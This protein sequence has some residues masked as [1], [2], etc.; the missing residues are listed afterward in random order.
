MNAPI[1]YLLIIWKSCNNLRVTVLWK[2]TELWIFCENHVFFS[3]KSV[4]K[5]KPSWILCCNQ[6]VYLKDTLTEFTEQNNCLKKILTK[7]NQFAKKPFFGCKK[8][9]QKKFQIKLIRTNQRNI[10]TIRL[11]KFFLGR[12]PPNIFDDFNS[13]VA[14]FFFIKFELVLR[15]F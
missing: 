6:E 9:W 10:K 7:K 8:S 13:L 2:I 3:I 11:R 14:C 15:E 4:V 1:N 5:W 12:F